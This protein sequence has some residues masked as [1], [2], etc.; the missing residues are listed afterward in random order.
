MGILMANGKLSNQQAFAGLR[1]ASQH[2]NRKLHD[3]AAEVAS[4]G[5]LPPVRG[6]RGKP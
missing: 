4:T 3:I 1:T 2:L 6:R 5:Q